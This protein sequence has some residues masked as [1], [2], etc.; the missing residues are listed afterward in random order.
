MLSKI[1]VSA[2]IHS[3]S[4]VETISGDVAPPAPFFSTD[5][6]SPLMPGS[7]SSKVVCMVSRS[8]VPLQPPTLVSTEFCWRASVKACTPWKV[9]ALSSPSC[10]PTLMMRNSK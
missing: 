5:M 9:R 8:C 1:S 7:A 3:A 6:M 10:A 4:S 2:A